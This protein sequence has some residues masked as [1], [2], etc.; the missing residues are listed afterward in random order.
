M[1]A[2]DPTRKAFAH[3]IAVAR[4]LALVF[5]AGGNTNLLADADAEGCPPHPDPN[6]AI[7]AIPTI[8]R[9]RRESTHASW[10]RSE[11][12]CERRMGAMVGAR[13]WVVPGDAGE[14]FGPLIRATYDGLASRYIEWADRVA[15]DL[16]S[17][18]AKRVLDRLNPGA[19][20]LELGC[21]PGL[22]VGAMVSQGCRYVGVDLSFEMLRHARRALPTAM[23]VQA[24]MSAVPLIPRS[25]DA[26][27]AFYSLFH[28]PREQH[29]AVLDAVA[30]C[31]RPGGWLAAILA[32]RATAIGY[33]HDWLGAGPMLWSNYDA[34]S[35]LDLVRDAGLV[36]REHAVE[37]IVEDDDEGDV[38]CLLAQ[39]P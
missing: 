15:P 3:A 33:E 26:V 17:R 19:L 4:R 22:P 23:L 29:A 13:D 6:A 37:H 24:D 7:T 9:A 38:L 28:V 34:T 21:G 27:L 5:P 10:P 20:V 30:G 12:L 16:R 39:R 2:S 32:S 14:E 1:S 8:T 18:Y 36:V 25:V 31:L 35:T 11:S